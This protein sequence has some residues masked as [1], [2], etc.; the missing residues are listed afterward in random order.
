[1][2]DSKLLKPVLATL[3]FFWTTLAIA[4][5]S[6]LPNVSITEVGDSKKVKV[7]IWDLKEDAKVTIT[8]DN[9]GI[10][11]SERANGPRFSKLYNLELLESGT[12][13]VNIQTG[14]KEVEQLIN[15]SKSDLKIDPKQRREFLLPLVKLEKEMVNVMMLNRRI[16][17]VTV[18]IMGTNGEVLYTDELGSVVKVE[19]RYDLAAL[20]KGRYQVVIQTPEKTYYRDILND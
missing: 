11:L 9:G 5:S 10:L 3:L 4:S 12:Y 17:E 14:Q 7:S 8:N 15:I 13:L 18:K 20:D 2:K 1:M 6:I 19:K 16:T